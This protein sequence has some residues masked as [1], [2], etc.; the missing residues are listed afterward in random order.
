MGMFSYRIIILLFSCLVAESIL[1]TRY[2]VGINQLRYKMHG[3]PNKNYIDIRYGLD[4]SFFVGTN[5]GLGKI[6]ALPDNFSESEIEDNLYKIID[7]NLPEGGNPAVKTYSLDNEKKLIIVSGITD[8]FD[9][10]IHLSGANFSISLKISCFNPN[11]SGTAS[12]TSSQFSKDCFKLLDFLI[13]DRHFLIFNF[14]TSICIKLIS[15]LLNRVSIELWLG[16]K[17]VAI[18]PC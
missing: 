10:K 15:I 17:T 13:N 8:V 16:S 18:H 11:F 9:A 4:G 3:W 1:P 2:A 7:S 6:E 5:G 14:E 12:I